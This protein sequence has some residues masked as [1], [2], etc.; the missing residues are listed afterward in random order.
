MKLPPLNDE[1]C[2]TGVFIQI[3][4]FYILHVSVI[5]LCLVSA[6]L[7]A[8]GGSSG[9][10]KLFRRLGVPYATAVA[11]M[12]HGISYTAALSGAALGATAIWAIGYGKDSV[13]FK[14][15]Y[16][17]KQN[18]EIS[19]FCTRLTICVLFWAGYFLSLLCFG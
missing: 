18:Q 7:W 6:L 17:L 11:L 19:D 14:Y 13:L 16:H 5:P 8:L 10:N 9:G 1:E 4:F 15:L 3:P 2:G 12:L